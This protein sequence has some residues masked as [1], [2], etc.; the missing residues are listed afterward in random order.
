MLS[1]RAKIMW[2]ERAQTLICF[3][4]QAKGLA[5][6]DAG[7]FS[8][9]VKFSIVTEKLFQ[10]CLKQTAVLDVAALAL[11]FPLAGHSAGQNQTAVCQL[12]HSTGLV[13]SP[14]RQW[15]QSNLSLQPFISVLHPHGKR[16]S[17]LK[18]TINNLVCIVMGSRPPGH[19][20]SA[21]LLMSWQF[22]KSKR[23]Y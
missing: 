22:W 10:S 1:N 9:Q 2:R 19:R 16:N 14:N 6:T 18:G 4:F 7:A 3:C 11:H 15:L 13:L 12:F 8:P 20:W 23:Y 5:E 21:L 17:E